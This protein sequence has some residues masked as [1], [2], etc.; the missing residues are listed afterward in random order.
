MVVS[1]S[2]WLTLDRLKRVIERDGLA[3]SAP[4]P[5]RSSRRAGS[6]IRSVPQTH[7]IDDR[8]TEDTVFTAEEA[9]CV[10]LTTSCQ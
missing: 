3:V 4:P 10:W 1:T 9:D 5:L 6:A 8:I 7:S 2:A